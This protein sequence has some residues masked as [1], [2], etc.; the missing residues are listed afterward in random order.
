MAITLQI[1]AIVL[2]TFI[3][4]LCVGLPV[5]I[6]PGYIHDSWDSVPW[7]QAWRLVRNTWPR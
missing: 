5:A 4:F 3:A 7:W 1:V 6:L 2:Y